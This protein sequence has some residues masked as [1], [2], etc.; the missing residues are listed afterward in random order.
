MSHSRIAELLVKRQAYTDLSVPTIL[1]SGQ[2]GIYYVNAQ[3]LVDTPEAVEK[4]LK[5][6]GGE[7][8]ALIKGI[9]AI[10]H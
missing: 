9:S 8:E 5:E 1:T 2:L 4:A 10:P 7:S 6:H 3:F